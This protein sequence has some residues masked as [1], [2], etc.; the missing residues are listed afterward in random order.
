MLGDSPGT[1]A[2]DVEKAKRWA[3]LLVGGAAVQ[4][5]GWWSL[6]SELGLWG[7]IIGGVWCLAGAVGFGP[8]TGAGCSVRVISLSRWCFW[9][10]FLIYAGFSCIVTLCV[11]QCPVLGTEWGWGE[12]YDSRSTPTQQH[13]DGLVITSRVCGWSAVFAGFSL[14]FLF[15]TLMNVR[16]LLSPANLDLEQ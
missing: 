5:V 2:A 16:A 3:L 4:Q 1:A 7:G 12:R 8:A 14:L 13:P 9:P 15:C 11:S 10:S 6:Y